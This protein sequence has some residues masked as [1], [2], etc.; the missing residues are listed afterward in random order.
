MSTVAKLLNTISQPV[1]HIHPE[2]TVFQ[3]LALM[4]E[5]GI[6][7]LPVMYGG[8]L[9]GI[10]SERDYARKVILKG[11]SSR[12]TPIKEIMTRQV[13]YVTPE[14]S[15]D[16]CMV[17]MTSKH[18]RHLPVIDNKKMIGLISMGDVVKQI[19]NEQQDRIKELENYISWEENY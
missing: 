12:D 17:I 6:G 11:R 2:E 8:Q 16:D 14:Q 4:D 18:I 9:V 5:K 15:M 10:V 3:A 7:A 1:W 13:L 19:I